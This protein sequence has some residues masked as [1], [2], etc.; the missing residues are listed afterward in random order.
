M[1]GFPSGQREQ[2]VNLSAQ[3]SEVR[4]LPPPPSSSVLQRKIH[5]E[6]GNSSIGR[7]SAFQAEGCEFESRFPLHQHYLVLQEV[8]HVAQLVERIL[9]KDEVTGSTPV[10]GSMWTLVAIFEITIQWPEET[11]KCQRK[12]LKGQNRMS[13]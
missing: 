3:P 13:M 4:I 1:E 2:T 7:A 11:R 9:G 6:S 5:R 10:V 8:A 12:N